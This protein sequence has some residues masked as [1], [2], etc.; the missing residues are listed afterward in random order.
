MALS[1]AV[2]SFNTGTGAIGTTVVVSGLGFAPQVVFFWWSGRT[3]TVDTTARASHARGFGAAVSATARGYV[4]TSSQ[5]TPT[6]MF[7]KRFQDDT[8][9]IGIIVPSTGLL[10]GLM[11]LQSMDAGGFT[12]IVDDQFT[13]DYRIHYLAIGGSDITNVA[14]STFA[15]ATV[16]GNQDITSLAFQPDLILLFGYQFSG[17]A[18]AII[19]DGRFFIGAADAAGNQGV[20]FGGS[21]D[22]AATS[23]TLSYCNDIEISAG[24]STTVASLDVRASFVSM[25]SNGFRLNWLE[26]T[27]AVAD[28][29]QFVALKG[30]SYKVGSLLT[31][32]D[33]TTD[34][35]VSGLASQPTSALF[36]SHGKAESVVDTFQDDDEL[37][38]GAFSSTSARA[39][40]ATADD[41]VAGTAVVSTSIEH[42]EVY[43][44]LDATT[45]ALEGLMDIKTVDSNGFTCI[46][47]D[48]DPAQSFVWYVTFGPTPVAGK[49]PPPFQRRPQ[50]QLLRRYV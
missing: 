21:N 33:T 45:G 30:G 26:Q 31:Q 10:D 48:A 19:A 29:I 22:G 47:D 28:I 44:N 5:D 11:D 3:E 37:S 34:I 50:Q 7:T 27:T 20:W 43:V 6:A 2:G 38:I 24:S 49:A 41:D 8:Q 15:K 25:L 14:Y 18:G 39:A 12:L 40:M 17:I 32:T 1:S 36:V 9:C 13:A 42:D 46:M 4:G 23:Q 35:V 16:T